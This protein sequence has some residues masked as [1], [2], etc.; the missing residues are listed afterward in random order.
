VGNGEFVHAPSS[1]KRVR[2]DRLDAPY[3]TK[4]ISEARRLNV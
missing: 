1:G 3:W 4:H 2:R